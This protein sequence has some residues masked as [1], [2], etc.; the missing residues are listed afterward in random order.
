MI[1]RKMYKFEG[2]HIVRNCTSERCRLSIH[3]H[4]YKV[5]VKLQSCILDYGGMVLDFGILKSAFGGIIDKFDHTYVLWKNED[6]EYK[7]NIK[8]MS[9]RWIEIPLNP[10]AECF[11]MLF[12]ILLEDK[13]TNMNFSNGEKDVNIHSVIVHETDTGYAEAFK[14]DVI[15]LE[16]LISDIKYSEGIENVC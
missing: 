9:D 10:T 13:L 2:A 12:F 14:Q 4:S 11:A 16:S 6:E 5:E 1:I 8:S 3:G 15:N 7:E